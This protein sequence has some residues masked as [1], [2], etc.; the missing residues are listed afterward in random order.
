MKILYVVDHYPKISESFVINEIHELDRRGHDIVVFSIGD[1]EDNNAHP[2]AQELDIPVY[3]SKSASLRSFP[4]LISRKILNI[5][6]LRRALFVDAPRKHAYWLHYSQ[7]ISEVLNAE[8]SIDIVHTHFATPNRLAVA[9]AAA[10]HDIPCTVTAHAHE[11]FSPSSLRRL[12]RVCARFDHIIV[13]SEYNRQYLLNEIGV[14]TEVSVVPATTRADKFSPSN[15]CVSNRLL[16]V[17]RLVEKKGHKY[18]IDAVADL[19][20]QGYD[21]EYHIVGTGEREPFLRNQVQERGIEDHVEFLGH[22]SDEQ[23]L[24]ELHEAAVFVLPC[25]ITADGDRDITPVAL[26]EAMAT[27]TACISTTISAIPEV[28]TNG[29]DGILVEPH[30]SEAVAEA[31]V[32]LLDNPSQ[33]QRLAENARKT[34]ETE[35]DISIT[36]ETLLAIFESVQ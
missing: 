16:T 21:I 32:N 36:T 30:N 1:P 22:I 7:Q 28:I 19:V 13:P 20:N 18:A 10:Y 4:D 24:D 35:F 34:I 33:R 23:L 31:I 3:Y 14:E 11:I 8:D 15:G 26:R 25:V 27:Q 2:E 29:H 12:K 5:P 6:V 9:Y 17:A